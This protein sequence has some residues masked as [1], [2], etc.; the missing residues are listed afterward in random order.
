MRSTIAA[1][2]AAAAV[3][4]PVLPAAADPLNGCD[5]TSAST[6][7]FVATGDIRYVAIGLAGC[8][9]QVIRDFTTIY[10]FSGNFPPTDVITQA[11]A[12]DTIRV[13]AG[14]AHNLWE[15]TRC[16]VRDAQ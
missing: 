16:I 3:A 9:I 2:L 7:Y 1:A 13:Y 4:V 8:S 5:T 14:F 6:C 11:D 12:G 15:H 10:Q